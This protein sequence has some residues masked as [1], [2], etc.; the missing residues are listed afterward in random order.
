MM[1][2][3]ITSKGRIQAPLIEDKVKWTTFR[4]GSPATLKF[5]V[6]NDDKLAFWEGDEVIFKYN[7]HEVFFGYVFKKDRNKEQIISVTCYSQERYLRNKTTYVYKNKKASDIFK[8]IAQAYHLNIGEI[9]DTQYVIANR[10]CDNKTL[11]DI[12][13]DGLDLT[14]MNNGKLYCLYDNFGK[15]NLK[16]VEKMK[17]QDLIINADEENSNM[18]DYK[19]STD[20]D[21]DTYNK[22]VLYKDNKETGKRETWTVQDSDNMQKWGVLQYYQQY[23]EDGNAESKANSIL[24][25]KNRVNRSFTAKS[26]KGDVR[27]RAGTSP[28]FHVKEIGDINIA[29]F[30]LIEKATH[31]FTTD[32]HSMDLDTRGNL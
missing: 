3:Y 1:E 11:Y 15:L 25:L 18:E 2:L 32:Y 29:Q 4:S 13:Y 27:A 31:T 5:K 30:L 8:D 7:G 14:L 21:K 23:K 19:Y 22:I 6:K 20:I 24:S 10:V 12:I 16:D 9:E 17:I 26:V 28:L